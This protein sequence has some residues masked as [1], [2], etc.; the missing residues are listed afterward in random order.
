MIGIGML[1]AGSIV[2][3]L[4]PMHVRTN[5]RSSAVAALAFVLTGPVLGVLL[6]LF[7]AAAEGSATHRVE[8]AS[9]GKVYGVTPETFFV[10]MFLF[11]LVSA[12]AAACA[13]TTVIADE[14]RGD[15]DLRTTDRP[16]PTY[17]AP[18][19][20]FGLTP[21][22]SLK[23]LEQA[24]R[25]RAKAVP[26]EQGGSDKALRKLQAQFEQAKRHLRRSRQ[27]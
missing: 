14:T 7:A 26:P 17:S 23:E 10:C 5:G 21:Y 22:S 4:V 2:F 27:V 13:F 19:Q 25:E 15:E 12:A 1:L 9:W 8:S 16:Y 20:A 3:A 11:G 6:F 24:Y 18:L